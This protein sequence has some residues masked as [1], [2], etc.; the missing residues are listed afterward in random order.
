MRRLVLLAAA[1]VITAGCASAR[2]TG[3]GALDGAASVVPADATAFVAA[4]TDLDS[5]EWHSV[6]KAFM[7]QYAK[8]EPALGDELDVAVLKG[9]QTIAFTEPRDAQKLAELAKRYK[10]VTR[11]I[12]GWT[13]IAKTAAALDALADAT[14]QLADSA[15]FTQAMSRLPD[16][17]LVRAYANGTSVERFI[18][19][20][21]G[22]M[23]TS[24]APAGIRYH[25]GRRYDKLSGPPVGGTGFRWGS[26]AV[27][28]VSEGFEVHAFA[29]PGPLT[30]SS[31]PRYIIHPVAPYRSALVD[32]IPAG[33]LAVA[34][35]QLPVSTF[36]N[37]PVFPAAV[38]RL[39]HTKADFEV[40]QELDALLGGETAVY[41]RASLP[42]PEITLV[43]QPDDTT[44]ASE[45]LDRLLAEAARKPPQLYR[46]VIGGQFVVSTSQAGIDAFRSGGTKLSADPAFVDAAKQAKLPDLTTGF[47]YANLK[48]ALPLLAL[49]GVKLPAG[50]PQLGSFLAYGGQDGGEST[51][52]AFVSVG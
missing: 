23:E 5:A 36:E 16:D 11:A 6:G 32:E 46:A 1:A 13:A 41:V 50:L 33:V 34:D 38:R 51:L 28:S 44:A 39:F 45:A 3:P 7:Q 21:P 30:A 8:L 22:Q 49:A 2:A 42:M 14:T 19:S 29:R 43:T 17:A 4:R 40:P 48:G 47:V 37:L 31:A 18:S 52:T 15:S 25:F 27:T 12:G 35:T 9:K 26:L 24:I 20:I 10:L